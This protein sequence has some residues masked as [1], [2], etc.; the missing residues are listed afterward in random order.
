MHIRNTM[1]TRSMNGSSGNASLNVIENTAEPSAVS[2]AATEVVLGQKKPSKKRAQ[3]PGVKKPV[4]SWMYWN[5][6]LKLPNNGFAT[7]IAMT[8]A[9]K[10]AIRPTRTS[11]PSGSTPGLKLRYRSMVKIVAIE[12]IIEASDETMAAISAANTSPRIPAGS[13]FMTVG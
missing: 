5:A 6:W 12:F 7:I 3:T 13:R 11:S 10:L 1:P 8:I 4:N 2:N 9:E